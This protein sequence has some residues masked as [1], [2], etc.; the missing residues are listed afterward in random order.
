[1]HTLNTSQPVVISTPRR[2]ASFAIACVIAPMPP[3]AW[4]QAP[5]LPFTSPIT[6]CNST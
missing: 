3:T 5:R 4:P 2:S 6:W 1:M